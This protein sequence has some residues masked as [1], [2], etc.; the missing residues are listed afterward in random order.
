MAPKNRL[1]HLH[2]LAL[3]RL[4][5]GDYSGARA[6]IGELILALP[7]GHKALGGLLATLAFVYLELGQP[8][9]AADVARRAV[10]CHPA[11]SV[12]MGL[13]ERAVSREVGT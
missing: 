2:N 5:T 10:K 3:R 13:L 7:P 11:S 1:L 12:A 8:G 6:P 4:R 9:R